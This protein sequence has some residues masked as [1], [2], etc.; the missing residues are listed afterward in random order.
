MVKYSLAAVLL[1]TYLLSNSQD[2]QVPAG[3]KI[4][5]Q[6]EG[7]LNKDS[8]SEKVIVFDTNDSA[9]SGTI[10]EIQ[11]YKK[12]VNNWELLAGSKNAIGQSDAGGMMGD[13]FEGIEIKDGILIIYQSGGSSW[14]WSKIDKYRF[15]N[16]KFQLIGYENY[17]GKPCEYFENVDFNL[18]TGKIVYEKEHE[19]CD[20]GEQKINKSET[21]TFYKKGIKIELTNRTANEI[22]IIT[23][24][25]KRE[26]YL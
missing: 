5:D 24:K 23:P 11:V 9:E 25:Y 19:N 12:S 8:V 1:L 14:K 26:I 20:E 13:P 3:Y 7:D 2:I 4:L 10:R 15:Q 6:K 21:E 16:G 22:K 17:Y 18:M